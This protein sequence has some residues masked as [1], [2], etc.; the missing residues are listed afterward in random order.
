MK[1]LFFINLLFLALLISLP[2]QVQAAPLKVVV[3]LQELGNITREIGAKEVDVFVMAKGASDPHFIV[4]KP[5]FIKKLSQADLY[6]QNGLSLEVGWA[7]ALLRNSRN[8]KMIAGNTGFLDTST[9]IT[10]QQTQ[11][12]QGRADRSMG[13][14]HPLGNPH[15]TTDPYNGLKVANLIHQRLSQL[16][17]DKAKQFKANYA[18]FRKKLA[19]A[20][21]GSAVAKKY[22]IEKLMILYDNNRLNAFL[23]AKQ[24][25]LGGWLGLLAPYRGT[26]VVADHD[27]WPYFS[28][29]YGL[30]V[31]GFMEP[32]P[33]IAPT[34]QQLQKLVKLMKG[35]KIKI[36]LS[37]PYFSTRYGDFLKKHSQATVLKMAHQVNARPDTDTYL[38]MCDYNVKQLLSALKK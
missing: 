14:I 27:L 13:D 18:A 34:T 11:M 37:V 28:S 38:K 25:K 24:L 12:L 23:K 33:G 36:V 30:K 15:Y 32:R 2:H 9:V 19:D 10:P 16:R 6:I 22:P 17:P 21:V 7:P 29:R 31:T 8:E 4:P 1:K 5:S 20:L 26:K 35:Q 3:T